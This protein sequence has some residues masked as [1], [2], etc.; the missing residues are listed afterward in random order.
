[1]DWL[2]LIHQIPAKPT[3]F[4]AR[5]RRRLDRVGAVPVKQA[6]YVMPASEQS[7]EDLTWIAKEITESG[8]DAVLISGRLLDGLTDDQAVAL[9][10]KA[11]HEDYEKILAQAREIMDTCR[12][13]SPDDPR[14]SDHRAVLRRLNRAFETASAIDFFPGPDQDRT[15]AFLSDMDTTLCRPP[16]DDPALP[17]AVRG[18]A[19]KI[20]VTRANVYVD[21]MASA[22]FIQRFIDPDARFRFTGQSRYTAGP[23]ELRF[24]MREAEYTHEGNLC[25]FEVL[26]KRFCPDNTGLGQIAKIIHDIDLKDDAYGLPET[27]GV[28]TLFDAIAATAG[29]DLER[30]SRAG[31]ILDSLLVSFTDKHHS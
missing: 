12:G 28:Q 15:G 20:W 11:R 24:D 4:R 21:R 19:G 23:D 29:N 3:S 17:K 1:M 5:I 18:L 6:V 14:L 30:I 27:V 22:W 25:T 26:A 13:I 7:N 10:Q 2:F 8:G 16:E 9:F 31:S